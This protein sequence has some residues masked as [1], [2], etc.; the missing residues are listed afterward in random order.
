MLSN[1]NSIA[2]IPALIYN[3]RKD[4]TMSELIHKWKARYKDIIK[5]EYKS[6]EYDNKKTTNNSN[7]KSKLKI[8]SFGKKQ[9]IKKI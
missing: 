2:I 6:G 5:T 8:G 1:V 4:N 9:L 3:C 7:T